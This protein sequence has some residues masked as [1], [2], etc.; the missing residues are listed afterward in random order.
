VFGEGQVVDTQY[1]ID[2]SAGLFRGNLSLRL[3]DFLGVGLGFTRSAST[4][5]ADVSV[6]VPHP[7][8]VNRP[9]VASREL[10]ALGHRENMFLLQAAW[11]MQ[12]DD[13]VNVQIFG[14]PTLMLVDQ[15]VV[16]DATAREVGPPFTDVRLSRVRVVEADETGIGFNVGFDFSYMIARNYGIGGFVQYT[17]GSIDFDMVGG[18]TSVTVGGL[19]FGGGLRLRLFD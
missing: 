4:G 15:A 2:R 1:E 6:E 14:G 7:V 3:W 19:Q 17:G 12:L 10:T 13:Q 11:L 5:V 18:P 8:F 9:R 16:V